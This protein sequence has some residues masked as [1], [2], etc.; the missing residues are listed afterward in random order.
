VH[1]RGGDFAQKELQEAVD[2]DA[3][4]EMAVQEIMWYGKERK[5]WLVFGAGVEHA[6]HIAACF[7]R[8]G[9]PAA[10]VHSDCSDEERTSILA[11]FKSGELRAV[12]N[13]NIL[14]TGFDFP[15]IDLI[16]VL[17]PTQSAVLWVQM[18]GRGTRPAEGKSNCLV[19]DF[20][21]NTRRLGPINDPVMPRKKGE[22]GPGQAPVR[23]CEACGA[24]NHASARSCEV[25][26]AE[27]PRNH[28]LATTAYT[29]EV[30]AASEPKIE[31]FR[32]DKVSYSVHEKPGRPPSLQVSYYCG[33]RLF[34]EWVCFEHD[35]YAKKKAHDW[36]RERTAEAI[37][38]TVQQ[39]A[40]VADALPIPK[41]IKVWINAK[42]PEITAHEFH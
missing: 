3:V 32:V 40:A 22:K 10:A 33:L 38:E 18:L 5:H 14:T 25:C 21:G 23:L 19:L 34:R 20:A 28:N 26:G 37:P 6:T 27:F 15:E 17:R 29:E 30:M 1:I 9:I 42:Y 8:H 7:E 35:G 41:E 16:G 11:R 39:A 4:T 36:W 12:V 24:Y 31:P 2:K 13:N